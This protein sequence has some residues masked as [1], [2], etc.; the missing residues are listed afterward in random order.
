M[1]WLVSWLVG[2]LVRSHSP[3][4]EA[5]QFPCLL[6]VCLHLITA[7]FYSKDRMA[8]LKVI[9][10]DFGT[11]ATES[12]ELWGRPESLLQERSQIVDAF[13]SPT[14]GKQESL[15]VFFQSLLKVKGCIGGI[16]LLQAPGYAT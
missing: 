5:N 16:V 9:G 1:V 2:W 12:F 11:Q 15:Q 10:G 6:E 7:G 14:S 4:N 8:L 3:F 13:Q